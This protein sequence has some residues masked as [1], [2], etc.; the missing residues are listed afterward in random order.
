VHKVTG[1]FSSPQIET[2]VKTIYRVKKVTVK[3]AV[4]SERVNALPAERET[5]ESP[6]S[7]KLFC[8]HSQV[9][10]MPYRDG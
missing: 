7:A 6:I 4:D 8:K 2:A 1:E 5:S 10:F 9:A 3:S